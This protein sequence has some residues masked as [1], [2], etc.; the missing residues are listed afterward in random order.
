MDAAEYEATYFIY[1]INI[2]FDDHLCLAVYAT[3]SKESSDSYYKA[4]G[5]PKNMQWKG[6]HIL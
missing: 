2:A 4:T 6:G 1:N 3:T 5:S